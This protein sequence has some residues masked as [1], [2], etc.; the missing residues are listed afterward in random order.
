MLAYGLLTQVY[1][2]TRRSPMVHRAMQEHRR[3]VPR[4]SETIAAYP[5]SPTLT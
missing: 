4:V 2:E 5:P 1:G 3:T